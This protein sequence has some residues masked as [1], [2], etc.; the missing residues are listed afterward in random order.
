MRKSYIKNMAFNGP[1]K[2]GFK[3]PRVAFIKGTELLLVGIPGET[4]C[5]S[6]MVSEDE[7][8]ILL[9]IQLNPD[10]K[11][12]EVVKSVVT[13]DNPAVVANAHYVQIKNEDVHNGWAF[14]IWHELQGLRLDI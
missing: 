1:I 3:V 13:C 14:P 2:G 5:F 4:G 8:G 10:F 12:R 7:E 11:P 6:V 9:D